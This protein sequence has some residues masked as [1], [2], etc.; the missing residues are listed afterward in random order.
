MSFYYD[1]PNPKDMSL[2]GLFFEKKQK[3]IKDGN[4]SLEN[5]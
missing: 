1:G 3:E 5:H 4:K 2:E